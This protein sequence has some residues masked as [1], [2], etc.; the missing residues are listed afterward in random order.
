MTRAQG[1]L[2]GHILTMLPDAEAARD[3]LQQTNLVLWRKR[4]E[5]DPAQGFLGWAA[6]IARFQVLAHLRDRDR[7]RHAFGGALLDHLAS[8][9]VGEAG[10]DLPGDHGQALRHCLDQLGERDRELILQRYSPGHSVQSMAATMGKTV[11][12]VSRALYRIRGLLSEC[13][14]RALPGERR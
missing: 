10:G 7:D 14:E 6:A 2:Y 4:G 3:V 1:W 5:Y 9:D 11:N 13:I 8:E 12:A